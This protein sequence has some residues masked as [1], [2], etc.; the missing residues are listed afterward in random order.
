[1]VAKLSIQRRGVRG[2]AEEGVVGKVWVQGDGR[3]RRGQ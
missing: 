2:G 3:E 1:M